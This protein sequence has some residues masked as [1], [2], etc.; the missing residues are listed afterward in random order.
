MGDKGDDLS[1]AFLEG[2]PPQDSLSHRLEVQFRDDILERAMAELAKGR[3]LLFV[4]DIGAGKTA[5]VAALEAR[6]SEAHGRQIR[7]FSSNQIQ[8]GCIYIGQWQS[9]LYSILKD[10][11]ATKTVLY[12]HDVWNFP[13]AGTGLEVQSGFWDLIEPE[14]QRTGGI[15]L[16][17]E[18]DPEGFEK[19]GANKRLLQ[20]FLVLRVPP[21]SD[22]DIRHIVKSY[23][24]ELGLELTERV[25]NRISILCDSFMRSARG[26]RPQ[27]EVVDALK[28]DLDA[29][30]G[31][32]SPLRPAEKDV[33]SVVARLTGLPGFVI[34]PT[35]IMRTTEI[36]QWFRERIIGQ[37]QAVEAVIEA[38]ALYKSGLHDP[39]KPVGTFFFIGPSGVGKTE[40]AKAL[41]LFLFGSE[42]RLLRF[43]LSEFA[44]YNSFEM[45]VGS[46]DNPDKEPRLLNPVRADPFQVI[47]FDEVEK[48]HFNVQ[49]IM[50]QLLDEGRVSPPRGQAVDFRSTIVI[51]TSNVGA[52]AA[53][54]GVPGFGSPVAEGFDLDRA[55][56]EMEAHFRPEFLNR[57]QHIVHFRPLTKDQALRVA[58]IELQK[59]LRREG[60]V[61]R[62]VAVDVDREVMKHLIAFGYDSRYGGRALQRIIQ[63][64]VVLPI[65]LTLM[66][67]GPS[68]GSLLQIYLRDER[69]AVAVLEAEEDPQAREEE[70]A[71]VRLA[72]GAKLARDQLPE[73]LREVE[74]RIAALGEAAGEARM[75]AIVAKIEE[76]R[77]D[78]A[79]WQDAGQAAARL[80]EQSRYADYLQRIDRVRDD[81][82]L[83][84]RRLPDANY[85][86]DLDRWAYD[87]DRLVRLINRT[88]R[89]LV[90]L[91]ETMDWPALLEISPTK[92]QAEDIRFLYRIYAD[93]CEWHQ[94]RV[95]L[96][97]EPVRAEEPVLMLIGGPFAYGYLKLEAG[98]H[99]VRHKK[100]NTG[101]LRV[102]VAPWQE[103]AG[104]KKRDMVST[105]LRREGLLGGRLRSRVELP[106]EGIVLQNAKSIFENSDILGSVATTLQGRSRRTSRVVRRYDL[107][108]F[109]I[110]DMSVDRDTGSKR[111]IGPELFHDLLCARIDQDT[112]PE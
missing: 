38:I 68:P 45:L 87:Y 46:P 82:H 56:S 39:G 108:P 67:R 15:Q 35:M 36:R 110:R 85:Q 20:N 88:Y 41:A 1:A 7:A 19:L 89:Q 70:R 33:E 106:E 86:A 6:L 60:I 47:L 81:H 97:C 49:D 53:S 79:F 101:I 84:Q 37:E 25:L 58:E 16:I 65:A 13:K 71:S 76:A 57:F 43:D 90:T 8:A 22:D 77:G 42:R 69:I 107:D 44:H 26:L 40:L 27:L 4:G 14:V 100:K 75:R 109:F 30:G 32:D 62:D 80:A 17:G 2:H 34:S 94:F 24:A 95:E 9:K 61:N 63:K 23:A 21:L 104:L 48:G 91:G 73:K 5:I 74:E 29:R 31:E 54:K 28:E 50:L 102:D 103:A 51:A 59:I 112:K 10:A 83:L 99:R 111:A 18:M 64:N 96:L 92:A 12:F 52:A 3:S 98:L 55:R 78:H 66:E 72:G 93:W 11:A 105:V